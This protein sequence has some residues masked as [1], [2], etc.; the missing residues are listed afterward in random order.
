MFAMSTE[1]CISVIEELER[2]IRTIEWDFLSTQYT[3]R[4]PDDLDSIIEKQLTYRQGRLL[5]ETDSLRHRGHVTMIRRWHHGAA[6]Y[7]GHKIWVS[8]DG[9]QYRIG[10][11]TRHGAEIPLDSDLSMGSI[12]NQ[13][14]DY[15]QKWAFEAGL[16][17]L[18]PFFHTD[19]HHVQTFA[20]TLR[21]KLDRGL[22]IR[23]SDEEP[24]IWLIC[25]PDGRETCRV[26]YCW[27]K[28]VVR[29]IKLGGGNPFRAYRTRVAES[30]VEVP[31]GF[32]VPTVVR[33]M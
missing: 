13:P 19:D 14:K 2:R 24:D 5:I 32:W 8:C 26:E 30:F 22:E 31:D 23:D 7:C 4:T 15:R 25:F 12:S 1:Q 10:D 33:A 29:S 11:R 21:C 28:G 18:A 3:L 27:S 9:A 17:Y 6:P 20:E 16:I